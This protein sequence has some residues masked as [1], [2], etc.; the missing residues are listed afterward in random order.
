MTVPDR[1][2][3]PLAFG[4]LAQARWSWTTIW[5]P[6]PPAVRAVL[7]DAEL[8]RDVFVG[9]ARASLTCSETTWRWRKRASPGCGTG[10]HGRRLVRSG[11]VGSQNFGSLSRRSGRIKNESL[12]RNIRA[13][14]AEDRLAE[15]SEKPPGLSRLS[16]HQKDSTG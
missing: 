6:S 5:E 2:A 7:L 11:R 12:R 9:W 4:D 14:D 3:Q 16:T 10:A 1:L 8:P 13:W 15:E